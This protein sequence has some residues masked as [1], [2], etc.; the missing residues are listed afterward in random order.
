MSSLIQTFDPNAIHG[1]H[2]HI[3]Y[4]DEN[5]REHAALLR[6]EFAARDDVVL[7]RWRDEPV[8]PHP[9]P[10]YQVAFGPELLPELL[11]WLMAVR[12]PL[13]ILVHCTTGKSDLLDHTAGA[14]WLGESLPL[15]TSI[16]GG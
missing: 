3:Y 4:R 9:L 6:E 10:M 2:A 1:Y 14:I 11:N 7:G 16:F 13:T 5:E 8:G 15:R 12:G